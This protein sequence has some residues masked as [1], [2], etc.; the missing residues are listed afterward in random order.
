MYFYKTEGVRP[1]K[2]RKIPDPHKPKTSYRTRPYEDWLPFPV[3][4][5]ITPDTFQQAQEALRT[6]IHAARQRRDTYLLTNGMLR[7]KCGYKLSCYTAHGPTYYRCGSRNDCPWHPCRTHVRAAVVD[8]FIWGF[9]V[10]TPCDDPGETPGAPGTAFLCGLRQGPTRGRR[11]G[12]Y[13]ESPPA[14]HSS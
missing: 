6:H 4:P 5:T 3:E 12:I 14:Y 2:A 8:A 9:I 13:R 10:A 11:D 7:C 1:R